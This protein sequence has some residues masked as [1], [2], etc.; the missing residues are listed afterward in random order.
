MR[1]VIFDLPIEKQKELLGRYRMADAEQRQWVRE[2]ID[3][4][5]ERHQ[6]ELLPG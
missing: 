3:Q 6:P 5:I 2:T 4:H 1:W